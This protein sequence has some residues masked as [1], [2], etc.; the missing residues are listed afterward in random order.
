MEQLKDADKTVSSV[1][2]R[3]GGNVDIEEVSTGS[4]VGLV[5]QMEWRVSTLG[6]D[7]TPKNEV[8]PDHRTS[9]S[10]VRPDA[11]PDRKIRPDLSPDR[12][13]TYYRT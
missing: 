12:N 2:G 9:P 10:L 5:Q 1:M 7:R 8:R 6:N 3:K 4:G 13:R 11:G